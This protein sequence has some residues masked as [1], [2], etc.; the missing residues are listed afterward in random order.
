MKTRILGE[1]FPN[2]H[3][4]ELNYIIGESHIGAGTYKYLISRADHLR[5][6]QPRD[7]GNGE[8]GHRAGE[9]LRV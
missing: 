4:T 3:R 2:T 9:D 8:P 7:L 5:R 6:P 1:L